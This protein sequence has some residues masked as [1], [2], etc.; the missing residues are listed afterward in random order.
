MNLHAYVTTNKLLNYLKE[1]LKAEM[2]SE[3]VRSYLDDDVASNFLSFISTQE[4]PDE[5]LYFIKQFLENVSIEE[6]QA[7][8]NSIDSEGKTVFFVCKN[9]DLMKIIIKY[10][11][12]I[13]VSSHQGNNALM[14]QCN[15][16]GSPPNLEIIEALLDT[17]ININAT[18]VHGKTAL[19]CYCDAHC[20]TFENFERIVE[21]FIRKG[22]NV[23]AISNDNLKAY[24]YI[25]DATLSERTSG[26][27]QG[28]IGL[29]HTK[30]A[31]NVPDYK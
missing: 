17:D 4:L 7:Y 16:R 6:A 18:N 24:D 21:L 30:S 8:I 2:Y 13:N 19:M 11:G 23:F 9:V 26:L 14:C 5:I 25:K 27:L 28:T 3:L 20:L 12:D 15:Y 31:R 10:V 22:A 29:N 1:N